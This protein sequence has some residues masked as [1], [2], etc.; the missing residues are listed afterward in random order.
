M[1]ALKTQI[2]AHRHIV[3]PG[4]ERDSIDVCMAFDGVS[5]SNLDLVGQTTRGTIAAVV[6][7]TGFIMIYGWHSGPRHPHLFLSD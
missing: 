4:Y 5:D 7:R 6:A 2:A 3:N 1:A